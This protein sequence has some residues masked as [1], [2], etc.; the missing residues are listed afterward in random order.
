MDLG[1]LEALAI[2]LYEEVAIDPTEPPSMFRVARAWLGA[3][4]VERPHVMA[5][6]PAKAY[7]IDGRDRIAVKASVPLE[8]ASFYIGHELGHLLL[9]RAGYVGDDEEAC[10]DYL[11][12]ALMMP[13]PA[14]VATYKAEGFAPRA[15]AELVG[16]TQTAAALRL[17]EAMRLPLAAVSPALVRVR[18]PEAFVWPDEGTIR[19]WAAR[20]RPGLMKVRLTDQPRRVALLADEDTSDVA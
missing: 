11:G 20:A 6:P 13:R 16:C 3:G 4:A 8:Y 2:Q 7:R 18:G 5:G 1:E 14:V 19:S 12:A 10:A 15:L 9:R 17:G